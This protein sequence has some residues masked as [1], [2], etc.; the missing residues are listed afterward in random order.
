MGGFRRE[1]KPFSGSA[2]GVVPLSHLRGN[3]MVLFPVGEKN[4]DC[5]AADA[6]LR[7]HGVQ[8]RAQF[9]PSG[10]TGPGG[11]FSMRFITEAMIS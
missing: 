9:R 3:E 2:G 5:R 11:I 8:R 6:V 7:V 1:Q 4:G 10:M